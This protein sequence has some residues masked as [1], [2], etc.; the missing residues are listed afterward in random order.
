MSTIA[1]GAAPNLQVCTP[2]G[3]DI[4]APGRWQLHRSSYVG[5]TQGRRRHAQSRLR[6]GWIDVGNLEDDPF[7]VALR[8]NHEKLPRLLM[9]AHAITTDT[10]RFARWSLRGEIHDNVPVPRP[11]CG[12]LAFHGVYRRGAEQ[13]AWITGHASTERGLFRGSGR[14][15]VVFDLI[16]QPP[17]R[18]T[19]TPHSTPGGRP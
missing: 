13:W 18:E 1:A 10:T 3:I 7:T 14:V 8:T 6:D 4:P 2:E 11:V 17:S 9:W 19:G 5:L 12:D 15:P 16:A